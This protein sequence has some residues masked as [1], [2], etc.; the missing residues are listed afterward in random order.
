MAIKLAE[1][2]LRPSKHEVRFLSALGPKCALP[3]HLVSAAH[4]SLSNIHLIFQRFV[5]SNAPMRMCDLTT[6]GTLRHR[7]GFSV[8]VESAVTVAKD[9]LQFSY[10]KIR[11][12]GVFDRMLIDRTDQV[13]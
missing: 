2:F 3:N 13:L 12:G 10:A 9:I 5:R 7:S 1:N 6:F 11:Y 4:T 8:V